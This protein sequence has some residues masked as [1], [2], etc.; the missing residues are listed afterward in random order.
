MPTSKL[1][2]KPVVVSLGDPFGIGPEIIKKALHS[3]ALNKSARF[4]VVGDAIVFSRY[5]IKPSKN[6]EL[7]SID[8]LKS[9]PVIVGKINTR[10]ARASVLYL[11]KAVE[12]IKLQN[13]RAIVTAPV[14]KE[15]I[16]R[17]FPGF[18]GH[19]E[20][21]AERFKAK[22]VGMMFVGRQIKTMIVTRHVPIAKVSRVLNQKKIIETIKLTAFAL[23]TYFKN[24]N[25]RLA[26]C[27]LNPHAGEGGTIGC[28]E[29]NVII[30]AIKKARAKGINAAG[31]FAADTLFIPSNLKRFDAVVAMYHD[32]GLTPVKA[33]C[34]NSLV[35]L[36]IGLPFVRTSPAHG[37]AFD[38]AGKG[39]A[40]ASSMIEAMNLAVKLSA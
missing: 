40:D 6:I 8:A 5:K 38:I 24:R 2:N 39:I 14:C 20:Y 28:E 9:L 30:P 35:N 27:G 11:E 33:M 22:E 12:L 36:T 25:P 26:V 10:S 3:P 16:V 19:T 13:A 23:K 1:K 29:K 21:L 7:L 4:L 18:S 15:G 37:T 34:F 31:P 17:S 32:Q